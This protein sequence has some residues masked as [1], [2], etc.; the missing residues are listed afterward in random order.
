MENAEQVRP[1]ARAVDLSPHGASKRSFKAAVVKMNAYEMRNAQALLRVGQTNS[2]IQAR[3]GNAR[4]HLT[5]V[6][7]RDCSDDEDLIDSLD[8]ST[9]ALNDIYAA[10]LNL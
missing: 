3:L 5:Q 4:D 6:L 7:L 10:L 8:Q 9:D 2:Q 1:A